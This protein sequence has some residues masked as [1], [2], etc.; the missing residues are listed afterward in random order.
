MTA[1][2]LLAASGIR[3]EVAGI[4]LATIESSPD[5]KH[6]HSHRGRTIW[7]WLRAALPLPLQR[8]HTP[9]HHVHQRARRV[10]Q[11]LQVKH[12]A[13]EEQGKH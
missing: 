11:A 6:I 13:A 1:S 4:M 9:Q 3:A 10:V 5:V 2:A 12:P 8:Q 7:R